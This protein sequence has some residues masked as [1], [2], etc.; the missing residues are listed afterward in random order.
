VDTS[1]VP[2]ARGECD[3]LQHLSKTPAKITVLELMEKSPSH[4]DTILR[5]L[6]GINVS[7][8]IPVASLAQAILS[9]SM[10][11]NKTPP[12]VFSDEEWALEEC[13]SLPLCISVALN[14]TMVD[15]VMIDT[16]ASIN[17]CPV[18][19]FQS[20]GVDEKEL[21][22][23]TTTV[24]AYDNTKRGARGGVKLQLK[25]GPTVMMTPFVI[26][27][28]IPTFKAILGRPWV[29]QTLGVP[30]TIH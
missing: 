29:Q 10:T 1:V 27:D 26:M 23:V 25:V 4:R 20:L 7:A 21:Q 3:I 24:T 13:R 12:V 8:D 15:S 14:D 28:I 5:F 2:N 18:N 19:T 17:V 11:K 16:G 30:S 6:Q 22:K 9:L